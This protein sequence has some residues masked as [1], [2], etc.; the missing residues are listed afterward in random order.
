MRDKGKEPITLWLSP[1]EK[2]RLQDLAQTWRCTTSEMLSQALAAFHPGS[3]NVTAT[4]TDTEQLRTLIQEAL[5]QTPNVSALVTDTVTATMARDLPAMVRAI[6]EGLALETL[7]MPATATYNGY[8]TDIEDSEETHEALYDDDTDINSNVAD[9][10]T[11]A[12]HPTTERASEVGSVTAT[13]NSDVTHTS[14]PEATPKA[15][16][17]RGLFKLT[18]RQGQALRAKRARGVPVKALM[19]EYGVSKATVFRYLAEG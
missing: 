3:P 2:L 18:P 16:L 8:E 6:V 7:G 1:E 19:E 9:T 5:V 4:I 14:T 11:Q 17:R 12:L 15:P 13:G 10:E